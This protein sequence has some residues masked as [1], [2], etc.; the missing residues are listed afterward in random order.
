MTVSAS[1]WLSD[2]SH[3]WC[4]QYVHPF[5]ARSYR[6]TVRAIRS[7]GR[8]CI[9]KRIRA[10]ENHED[11]PNDIL[12][13]ILKVACKSLCTLLYTCTCMHSACTTLT[14]SHVHTHMCCSRSHSHVISTRTHTTI[15]TQRVNSYPFT[16]MCAV[17]L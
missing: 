13:N 5:E 17:Y 1:E 15:Q 6:E 16:Y 10:F 3:S 14:Q 9:R 2:V 4:F 8:D 12:T 7:I 11:L